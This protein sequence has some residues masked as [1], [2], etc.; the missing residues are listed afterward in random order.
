MKIES[1]QQLREQ[2][3]LARLRV[4]ELEQQIKNDV[5]ELKES[6]KPLNMARQAVSG[7]L[8]SDKHGMV[9][10]SIGIT[11]DTLIKKLLFRN[12]GFLT[13]TLISFAVKNYANG[14]VSKKS[15]DILD[16]LQV[17][18]KKLKSKHHHNGYYDESTADAG[19]GI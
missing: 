13:K 17:H 15:E 6:F 11:V 19:L 9:S 2:R 7:M 3:A 8:S 4:K 5:D 16:W 14:M 18:I 12:T 10:E 1:Y